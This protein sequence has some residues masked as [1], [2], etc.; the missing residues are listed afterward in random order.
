MK[1]YVSYVIQTESS[2]NFKSEVIELDVPSSF[3]SGQVDGGK[4]HEWLSQKQKSVQGQVII[5]DHF[6]V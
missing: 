4:L 5:L 2:T 1:V 3:Y 6:G